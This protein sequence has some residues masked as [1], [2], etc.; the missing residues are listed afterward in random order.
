MYKMTY[1]CL[2]CT[3]VTRLSH[4]EMRDVLDYIR[5]NKA[6]SELGYLND[7]RTCCDNPDY[8]IKGD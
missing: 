6:V 5:Q 2:N 1:I 4:K 7:V 8:V 3:N